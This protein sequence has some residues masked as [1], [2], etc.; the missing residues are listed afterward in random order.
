MDKRLVGITVANLD[1]PG[2]SFLNGTG[3]HGFA[4]NPINMGKKKEDIEVYV[5]DAPFA[6]R[7][8]TDWFGENKVNKPKLYRKLQW[9]GEGSN[10]L[11]PPEPVA[12]GFVERA[13]AGWVTGWA[14]DPG[15]SES[16]YVAL[17]LDKKNVVYAQASVPRPALATVFGRDPSFGFGFEIPVTNTGKDKDVKLKAYLFD[18]KT[19]LEIPLTFLDGVDTKIKLPKENISGEVE[20]VTE[21]GISGWVYD[22][23]VESTGAQVVLVGP[24]GEELGKTLAN[25]DRPDLHEVNGTGNKLGFHIVP[26]NI[27]ASGPVAL[28]IVIED[29]PTG[30]LVELE[31][32]TLMVSQPEAIGALE[33]SDCDSLY[34]WVYDPRLGEVPVV[35]EVLVDGHSLGKTVANLPRPGLTWL[36]GTDHGFGFWMPDIL[37]E[38]VHSVSV[39]YTDRRTGLEV[40]LPAFNNADQIE[41]EAQVFPPLECD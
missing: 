4:I 27:G 39:V 19:G 23:E 24:D 33:F 31:T 29:R 15:V 36:E 21:E 8:T 17:E 14:F 1:R 41:C 5:A 37:T 32:P 22:P 16:A 38:G 26:E 25:I 40:A 28:L 20:V 7:K 18:T 10:K 3:K 9:I 13:D 12:F 30:N 34:G 35:V 6:V 11:S 2:L